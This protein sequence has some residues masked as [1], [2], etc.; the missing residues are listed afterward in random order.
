MLTELLAHAVPGMSPHCESQETVPCPNPTLSRTPPTVT[1]LVAQLQ[2]PS[3]ARP[4]A[5]VSDLLVVEARGLETFQGCHA[6]TPAWPCQDPGTAR[7]RAPTQV[8]SRTTG[9]EK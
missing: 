2:A 9:M 3:E 5:Q 8:P 4:P 1:C 6:Q 7:P